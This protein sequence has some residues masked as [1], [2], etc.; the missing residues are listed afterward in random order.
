M[1]ICSLVQTSSANLLPPDTYI[2]SIVHV[3]SLP[4]LALAI[5][6]SDDTL[7]LLDRE[8]LQ[9]K[10]VVHG[11]HEGVTAICTNDSSDG[12]IFTAGRDGEVRGW[13]FRIGGAGQKAIE[14][15]GGESIIAYEIRSA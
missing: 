11:V 13:D 6:S 12:L 9:Q 15:A 10:H 8:T 1:K 2:Y 14:M 4:P 7:R 3:T 5:L